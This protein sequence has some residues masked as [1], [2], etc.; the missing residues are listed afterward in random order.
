M[1]S[2]T[3]SAPAADKN[4]VTSLI[5]CSTGNWSGRPAPSQQGQG[6]IGLKLQTGAAPSGAIFDLRVIN[7]ESAARGDIGGQ[8]RGLPTGQSLCLTLDGRSVAASSR[9]C[10]HLGNPTFWSFGRR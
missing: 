4:S 7:P 1:A 9:S 5:R 10:D 3:S 2:I 8:V 6:L